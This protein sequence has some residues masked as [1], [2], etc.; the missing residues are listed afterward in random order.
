MK[1]ARSKD[2]KFDNRSP[3]DL[4]ETDAGAEILF[5]YMRDFASG[6]PTKVT[7]LKSL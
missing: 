2:D 1:W 7:E 4:I 5:K 3:I 6:K